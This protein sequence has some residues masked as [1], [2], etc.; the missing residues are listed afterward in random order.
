M[1]ILEIQ[2]IHFIKICLYIFMPH[3]YNGT[4]IKHYLVTLQT[5][6]GDREK[7]RE[8][9]S[10]GFHGLKRRL[11]CFDSQRKIFYWDFSEFSIRPNAF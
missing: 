7:I 6:R 10:R 9:S 5:K 11:K 8:N 2:N 1:I 3:Y 4:I